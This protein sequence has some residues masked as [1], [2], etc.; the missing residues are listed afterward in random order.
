MNTDQIIQ[1]TGLEEDRRQVV[2]ETGI[3]KFPQNNPR[4]ALDYIRG[5]FNQAVYIN[6][7]YAGRKDTIEVDGSLRSFVDDVLKPLICKPIICNIVKFN[8]NKAYA[9]VGDKKVA[10][11]YGKNI[12]EFIAEMATQYELVEVHA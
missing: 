3:Y 10:E 12:E 4:M 11:W 5:L 6:G 1:S 9:F 2:K 8:D 7:Q